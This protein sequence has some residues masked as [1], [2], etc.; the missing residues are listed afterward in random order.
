M[1]AGDGNN[2][3]Y[4]GMEYES[5]VKQRIEL[6]RYLSGIDYEKYDFFVHQAGLARGA[7][8]EDALKNSTNPTPERRVI[9]SI[10]N[11]GLSVYPYATISETTNLVKKYKSVWELA[12]NLLKYTYNEYISGVGGAGEYKEVVNVIMAIPKTVELMPD[13]VSE[14]D[15]KQSTISVPFSRIIPDPNEKSRKYF[16]IND[17]M[18]ANKIREIG[19][20]FVLG[21]TCAGVDGVRPTTFFNERF[22]DKLSPSEYNEKMKYWGELVKSHYGIHVPSK[23]AEENN[24]YTQYDTSHSATEKV[25]SDTL[26]SYAKGSFAKGS[27]LYDFDF[28]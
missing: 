24:L 2:E 11:C 5:S 22:L 8:D 6:A 21:I 23:N 25:V 1:S 13:G 20:E 19:P 17:V 16:P 18:Y 12:D 7:T 26:H 10:M 3:K 28:Y 27:Y 9:G 14:F 4:Y 15:D